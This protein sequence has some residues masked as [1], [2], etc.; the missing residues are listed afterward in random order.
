MLRKSSVL[1]TALIVFSLI[2]SPA[3]T[4]QA[5]TAAST[6]NYEPDN[7]PGQA[8]L[9]ASGVPQT[10]SIVPSTDLDWVKFQLTTT[11]GVLLETSGTLNS[12]TRI[13]L[14]TSNLTPIEYHDDTATSFWS[15]ID[16]TCGVDPLP[17]GT[18]YVKVEEYLNNAQIPSYNIAFDASPCPAEFLNIYMGSDRQGSSLLAPHTSIRR[19]LPGVSSGPVQVVNTGSSPM[20]LSERTIYTV[21]GVQTSFA[22]M[23]ALPDSNLDDTYWLPWYNN[24]GLDTQLRIANVSGATATVQVF[25]GGVP[26]GAPFS[27][28]AGASVRKSYRGV[29]NGPVRIASSQK[30]VA[31]ERV[32]YTVNGVQTSFTE[33]MALPA[34]QLDTIYWLPWYNQVGLDTELRI[35]NITTTQAT[36]HVYIGG[37]EMQGSPFNLAGGATARRSYA[38][39]NNGPVKIVSDQLIV[40]AERVIY[41]VNGIQTSFTEMM[42]LPNNQLSKTYWMPWYNYNG[43]LD[44]QLRI[45]NVSE[46]LATVRVYIGG[47]QMVDSP[48]TLGVGASTRRSYFGI[49][50]GPVQIVS[51]QPIVA[52]ERFIYKVN[53]VPTSFSEMMGLPDQQLGLTYWLPWYNSLGLDTQ[54]RIG[55]P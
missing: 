41:K 47:V 13:S 30:I 23:M 50:N 7:T 44:T 24:T 20:M 10:H 48:F 2:V 18:Y 28:T 49:N 29:N 6:N 45:A 55:L 33:M 34:T 5:A 52:A 17:A 46:A 9:I 12:D 1:L 19:S 8:K 15:Y 22:E 35:A 42:A 16:R 11:S 31:A 37:V 43:T 39:V 36:I 14:Y 25:I 27:L 26:M 3:G 21:N 54:L 4:A 51:D 53:N 40:A 38:G 32:I